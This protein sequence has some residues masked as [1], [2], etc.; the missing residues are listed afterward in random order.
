[1]SGYT[2]GEIVVW[3]LL[4]AALG[5]GLGWLLRELKYR[6]ERGVA[7]PVVAAVTEPRAEPTAESPAKKAPAKKIPAKKTPAK[8]APAKKIPAKKI[9][10][11]KAPAKKAPAKKAPAKKAPSKKTAT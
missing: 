4:A 10:A 8:K 11:K 2:I 5:F 7:S 9:P 3:L 6:S 1:M